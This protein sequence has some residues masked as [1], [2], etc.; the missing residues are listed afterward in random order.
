MKR[1]TGKKKSNKG[2]ENAVV[3][4]TKKKK[5]NPSGCF[6]TLLNPLACPLLFLLLLLLSPILSLPTLDQGF[7]GL[8]QCSFVSYQK[9]ASMSNSHEER[10]NFFLLLCF[11]Y[12]SSIS[13]F[14]NDPTFVLLTLSLVPFFSFFLLLSIQDNAHNK[15]S[16]ETKRTRIPASW[17]PCRST[18]FFSLAA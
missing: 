2:R 7:N 13:I 8:L 15:L 17:T 4:D 12:T 5:T 1:R 3:K 9:G 11:H 6:P 18:P 16:V 10:E 14:L